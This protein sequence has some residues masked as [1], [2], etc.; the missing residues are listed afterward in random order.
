MARAL[1][2]L[3]AVTNLGF[4]VWVI[5]DPY[6]P[7]EF[8]GLMPKNEMAGAELRTMYGGLIGGLGVINL[9]GALKPE[10]L[11]SA[12]WATGWAFAGVGIVRSASCIALA[13]SGWQV[14][15]A[16]SELVAAA[17][18]F[19]L[20]KTGKCTVDDGPTAPS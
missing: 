2:W 18:C 5:I 20:L 6:T 3:L 14:V 12:V 17:V 13:I 4:M 7:A 9:V 15:F 1:M 16:V 8:V 10:R 11:N 19:G